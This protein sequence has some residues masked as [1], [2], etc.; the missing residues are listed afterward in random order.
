MQIY[1]QTIPSDEKLPESFFIAFNEICKEDTTDFQ[2]TSIFTTSKDK[3]LQIE[4]T[5]NIASKDL[6]NAGKRIT[7]VCKLPNS[8]EFYALIAKRQKEPKLDETR[9]QKYKIIKSKDETSF[10][11]KFI[12]QIGVLFKDQGVNSEGIAVI[13]SENDN[14]EYKGFL[15]VNDVFCKPKKNS[16]LYFINNKMESKILLSLDDDGV[17]EL[18]DICP[19]NNCFGKTGYLILPQSLNLGCYDDN[20]IS[21]AKFEKWMKSNDGDASM[22]FVDKE[23]LLKVISSNDDE[24]EKESENIMERIPIYLENVNSKESVFKQYGDK[25]QGFIIEGFEALAVNEKNEMLLI[26]EASKEKDTYDFILTAKFVKN[27]E[28]NDKLALSIDPCKF[29]KV[30]NNGGGSNYAQEALLFCKL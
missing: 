12:E 25:S 30:E 6:C 8:N 17:A 19:I 23:K 4:S 15:I 24:K 1:L 16:N 2:C 11:I 5:K 28:T 7:A 29:V 9:I 26:L 21:W 14:E 20:K 27:K 3:S 18:N 13:E 22:F 10:D